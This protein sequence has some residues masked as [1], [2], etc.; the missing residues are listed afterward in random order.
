M[1]ECIICGKDLYDE[2]IKKSETLMMLSGKPYCEG[3]YLQMYNHSFDPTDFEYITRGTHNNPPAIYLSLC[4]GVKI[5]KIKRVIAP[6]AI[7]LPI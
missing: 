4:L 2:A 3:C 1:K 6:K 7:N 5:E